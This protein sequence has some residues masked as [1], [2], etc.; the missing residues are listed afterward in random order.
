MV[1]SGTWVGNFGTE[2][3]KFKSIK[4]ST[5]IFPSKFVSEAMIDERIFPVLFLSR[6]LTDNMGIQ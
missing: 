2:L 5:Y 1:V 3:H 4:V 6:Y